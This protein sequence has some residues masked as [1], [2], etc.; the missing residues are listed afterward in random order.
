MILTGQKIAEEVRSG[1]ITI[2]PFA[3]EHITTNSYDL[4]LGE[5]F[6]KYTG[7]IIDSRIANEY[8]TIVCSPDQPISMQ[9]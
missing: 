1:K 2:T 3:P 6:I 7:S 8:E 5:T 9:K 4:T